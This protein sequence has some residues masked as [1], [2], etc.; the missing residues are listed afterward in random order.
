VKVLGT[1]DNLPRAYPGLSSVDYRQRITFREFVGYL[2]ETDDEE[3]NGHW[4]P[5]WRFLQGMKWDF[6]GKLENLEDDIK[7]VSRKLNIP[8]T[9]LP[10][11]NRTT[12]TWF[13]TEG[14]L[15][16]VSPAAFLDAGALPHPQ[17]LWTSDLIE[18]IAKRFEKDILMFGYEDSSP[19]L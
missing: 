6:I 11:K 14:P 15:A 13:Q 19:E 16:D 4:R 9:D 7:Y 17:Q 5:Q 18:K 3:L 2:C 8:E 10:H 12:Y 1:A